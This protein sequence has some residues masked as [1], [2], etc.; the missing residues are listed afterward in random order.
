VKIAFPV[1]GGPVS[2]SFHL[3]FL[4]EYRGDDGVCVYRYDYFGTLSGQF[5]PES[6]KLEGPVDDYTR[7]I[8]VLEGCE[9]TRFEQPEDPGAI[10]WW[11]TYDWTTG[12]LEGELVHP[13][14]LE[15]DLRFRDYS[16]SEEA[17]DPLD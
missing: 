12:A 1:D 3:A 2:G 6:G 13:P 10:S 8:E 17:S 7:S 9:K 14:E 15:G 11:A 5:D 16:V 4:S